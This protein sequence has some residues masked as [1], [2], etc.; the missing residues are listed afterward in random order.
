MSGDP[1]IVL[2]TG[3]SRG[4]G[5]AVARRFAALGDRVAVTY[6]SA[7][8]PDGVFAVKCDVTSTG[9]VD[10]AFKAVE[11]HFGGPVEILV[12]NAGMNRDMLLLRMSEED[13]AP[14][15]IISERGLARLREL[16]PE[17][18][19]RIQPGLRPMQILGLF[20]VQTFANLV[21]AKQDGRTV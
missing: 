16:M 12:S 10:E 2:V 6:R 18:L 3:G 14:K 5:L 15:G 9:D 19:A 17:A 7:D 11:E 8:P 21:K 20:S 13:F 4:I 1:R